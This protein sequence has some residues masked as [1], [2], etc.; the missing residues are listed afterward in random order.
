MGEFV[1]DYTGLR[2]VIK[3]L[4]KHWRKTLRYLCSVTKIVCIILL[5]LK[6]LDMA[7]VHFDKTFKD[8]KLTNNIY[9]NLELV[10]QIIIFVG[11]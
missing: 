7:N 10:K 8:K 5:W 9:L 6:T 2:I 1:T 4:I 11:Y 3:I